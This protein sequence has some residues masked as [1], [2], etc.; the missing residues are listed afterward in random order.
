MDAH[1]WGSPERAT[2]LLRR[3]AWFGTT[4]EFVNELLIRHRAM[5]RWSARRR[6]AVAELHR[7]AA[8]KLVELARALGHPP[9]RHSCSLDALADRAVLSAYGL[10]PEQVA[11]IEARADT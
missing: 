11:R 6:S 2:G 5:D 9:H 8:G 3:N 7:Q 4:E 1:G 10:S